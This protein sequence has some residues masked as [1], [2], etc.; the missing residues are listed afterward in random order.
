MIV[1]FASHSS[2]FATVRSRSS[3]LRINIFAMAGPT[4]L[5]ADRNAQLY[6]FD[7]RWRLKLITLA[8]IIL[9]S[10][11][12][13]ILFAAAIPKWNANFFHNKGPMRGDWTDGISIGPLLFIFLFSILSIIHFFSRQ[14]P[15]PPRVCVVTFSLILLSLAPSLFLAGHGSLFQHWRESAVRSQ[16]GGLVCN[17]LNIFSRECEPILYSVGELQI[18]GIVFG[19]LVWVLVFVLLL[20]SIYETR[21][22]K[23]TQARLPRR[24]TLTI[25]NME[26]G[27]RKAR[28]R[29]Q[30]GRHHH[31]SRSSHRQ[32]GTERHYR[33]SNR[34]NHSDTT[35][36]F[37]VEEPVRTHSSSNHRYR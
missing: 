6:A 37:H 12:A 16:N 33:T 21:A 17:L 5:S 24:L 36:I 23:T 35:P 22:Q 1:S 14:K 19:S 8:S 13:I 26:K 29:E 27:Y 31:G 9:L 30:G 10:F 4:I 2:S 34:H 7:P 3:H 20:V 11:V 15:M 32:H 28:D 25:S 18:G